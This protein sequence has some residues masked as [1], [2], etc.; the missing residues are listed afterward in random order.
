MS[1]SRRPHFMKYNDSS[2]APTSMMFVHCAHTF[3]YS[4]LDATGVNLRLK[5]GAAIHCRIED[6]RVTRREVRRFANPAEFWEFASGKLAVKRPLSIYADDALLCWRLVGGWRVVEDNPDAG[7]RYVLAAPPVVVKGTLAAGTVA[8]YDTRNHFRSS[9]DEL[10]RDIGGRDHPE[11]PPTASADDAYEWALSRAEVVEGAMLAMRSFVVQGDYGVWGATIAECAMHAYRHRFMDRRLAIHGDEEVTALERAAL[12]G[13]RND[14]YF[15]GHFPGEAWQVD[16][17]SLY[18]AVMR[19]AAMPVALKRVCRRPTV[20]WLR[21][22]CDDAGLIAKVWIDTSD[23]WYPKR[24]GERPIYPVGCFPTTLAGPEL[25]HALAAGRVVRVGVC[26]VYS[27]ADAFTGY[28]DHFHE[29][30]VQAGRDGDC[31]RR[32]VAK[33]YLNAL[34]GKFGQRSARHAVHPGITP[35]REWGAFTYFDKLSGVRSQ[36][37]AIAGQA[38]IELEP[39]DSRD[40]FPALTATI[41]SAARVWMHGL[42]NAAGLRSYLY[43]DTDSLIVTGQGLDGIALAGYLGRDRPGAVRVEER[44]DG[45]TIHTLKDYV[46]GSKCVCGSVPRGYQPLGQSQYTGFR[47]ET[48]PETVSFAGSEVASL[49]ADVR[50]LTRRYD[51]RTAGEG[52]WTDPPRRYEMFDGGLT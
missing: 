8:M 41:N 49:R 12:F 36:C 33:L 51:K 46:I 26:A 13:G 17:D 42:K 50:R 4:S 31:V 6:G 7:W 37:L 47:H 23:D 39:E 20:Q 19:G 1:A 24:E 18:P 25:R 28:V 11:P 48:L 22:N 52:G 30:K 27:L 29:L 3:K 34:A 21:D 5:V 2:R 38:W 43:E 16:V 35:P 40:A 14:C 45:A 15:T 10:R 44:G 9:L 32:T